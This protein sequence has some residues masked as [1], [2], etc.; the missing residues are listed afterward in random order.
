MKRSD[1]LTSVV[2]Q[3][4]TTSG[5]CVQRGV[6][7]CPTPDYTLAEP[8]S[9]RKC[10]VKPDHAVVAK[11]PLQCPALNAG[12]PISVATG[13]VFHK[14]VDLRGG[15]VFP[16][17]VQR[18]YNSELQGRGPSGSLGPGWRHSYERS[19]E[20]ATDGLITTYTVR[21]PDGRAE[22]F[23]ES[24]T[25]EATPEPDGRGKL[26]VLVDV[27][28]HRSGWRY[29]SDSDHEEIF[30]RQGRLTSIRQRGGFTQTLSYSPQGN[31]H[32]VT[33]DTD[34]DPEP[35]NWRRS[36]TFEYDA[37]TGLLDKVIDSAGAEYRYHY[38]ASAAD[39][40]LIEVEYPDEDVPVDP[41]NDPRRRYLYDDPGFPHALTGIIDEAHYTGSISTDVP[42]RAEWSYDA[43]GRGIANREG[44][45]ESAPGQTTPI[46]EVTLAFDTGGTATTVTDAL[47]ETASHVYGL[48]QGVLLPEYLDQPSVSTGGANGAFTSDADGFFTALQD[49]ESNETRREKDARN[50]EA[51]RIEAWGTPEMRK[52]TTVW[53]PELHVPQV[54][55]VYAAQQGTGLQPASCADPTTTW[56]GVTQTT[57]TWLVGQ[58]R[59]VQAQD[60]VTSEIRTVTFD[61]YSGG[62]KHGLL[63]SVDG[64]RDAPVND[65]TTFNYDSTT[66]VLTSVVNGL[67]HTISVTG[68]DAHGRPTDFIDGNGLATSLVYH[69]RGWLRSRTVD[70]KKT[71][72]KYNNKGKLTGVVRPSG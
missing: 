23:F 41:G 62:V 55:T 22:Y 71:E 14:E 44:V 27:G 7:A 69:P 17:T 9:S 59:S 24:G 6:A 8:I 53:E 60:L 61:Y 32:K 20:T 42:R 3:T 46:T 37:T 25:L 58:L 34:P 39:H 5:G 57:N 12:H 31:L 15:G 29:T 48:R 18:F 49:Y 66:G 51:C 40:H 68:H 1:G 45:Y 21:R 26:T 36:L 16:L 28:G 52:T 67:N 10:E 56:V 2:Y 50:L 38:E 33:D 70:G 65:V 4:V 54:V 43:Q 63:R 47:N 72:F 64:P 30:D 11:Q 35:A 13:N 19:I